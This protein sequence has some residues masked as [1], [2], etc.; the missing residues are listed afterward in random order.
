[1]RAVLGNADAEL[2]DRAYRDDHLLGRLALLSVRHERH[3]PVARL[4]ADR[5]ELQQRAVGELDLD[6]GPPLRVLLREPLDRL[7]QAVDQVLEGRPCG[8]WDPELGHGRESSRA[9]RLRCRG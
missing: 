7:V 9:A 6:R 2:A 5:D 4:W 3:E 8:A 1:V